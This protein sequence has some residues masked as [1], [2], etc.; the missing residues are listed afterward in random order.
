MADI[1]IKLA[2]KIEN[3]ELRNKV[4]EI[5]KS[6]ELSNP[7][8]KNYKSVPIHTSPAG[9]AGFEHHMVEGGLVLH[10]KN[11]VELSLQI[12]DFIEKNYYPVNKDYVIAGA[13]L[14][15][16]MRIFDFKKDKKGNYEIVNKLL[17]HSELIGCELYARG[18]PEEV[19]HIVL[20]HLGNKP[21]ATLEAMIVNF[22]DTIDSHVDVYVRGVLKS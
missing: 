12:A 8:M 9:Y 11:V 15:D 5:L 20:S 16:I 2:D 21:I 1:L 3:M 14:H 18:F 17:E 7:D 10:T 19:I 4:K 22:A 6:P 13:L